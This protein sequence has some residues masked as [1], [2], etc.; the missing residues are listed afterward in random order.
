M[1]FSKPI[2]KENGTNQLKLIKTE[3]GSRFLNVQGHTWTYSKSTDKKNLGQVC[4][5]M[6]YNQ[7]YLGTLL[8][9]QWLR[10]VLPM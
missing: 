3:G 5:R 6:Q 8:V 1:T 4:A 10:L 7:K 9:V 2:G